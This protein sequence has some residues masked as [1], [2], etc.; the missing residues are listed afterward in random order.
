MLRSLDVELRF[1]G[2]GLEAL[3]EW[4]SYRP[5]LI[6]MDISMPGMDGREATRAIRESEAAR[7]LKPVPIIA[8][9]AHAMEGDEEGIPASGMDRYLTKPLRKSEISAAVLAFA[10]ETCRPPERGGQG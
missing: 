10:A 4:E 1:A 2:N 6:F 7:G 5:D 8:L 9:T 3:A